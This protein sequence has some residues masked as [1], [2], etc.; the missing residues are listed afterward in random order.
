MKKTPHGLKIDRRKNL[1]N[2]IKDNGLEKKLNKGS[3]I[4]K[5]RESALRRAKRDGNTEKV[6]RLEKELKALYEQL[7]D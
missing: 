4:I 7:E 1:D 5:V 6:E 2:I 3:G